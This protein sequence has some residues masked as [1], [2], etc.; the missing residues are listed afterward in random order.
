MRRFFCILLILLL[1]VP[2]LAA[3]MEESADRI[4]EV[5]DGALYGE[6][7]QAVLFVS[8]SGSDETGDGSFEKPFRSLGEAVLHA[9]I[10]SV[11]RMDAGV[12]EIEETVL[13]PA[14]VSVEGA[15]PCGEKAIGGE[16]VL[17]S[18]TLTRE[19]TVLLRLYSE[20]H[21]NY[22][23]TDGNQHISNI[24]FD[25][26]GIAAQAIEV[27]NRNF[28]SVHDC[29]I[30]NFTRIGA[31]FSVDDPMDGGD[32][33]P[34]PSLPPV[35]FAEGCRFFG[36]YM[37]DNS[38]YGPD[39]GGFVWGR[40]AL[41][42]GGL[43]DFRVY[44]NTIIEDCRTAPENERG[45]RIRGVP[46]KFWYFSGW[47]AGCVI[48]DNTIMKLGSTVSSADADG[49]DFA[50]ESACHAG[51]E[52]CHNTF[53]GAIDLNAGMT[54]TFGGET[55]ETATRIHDNRFIP[56]PTPK[57][58]GS[59]FEEWAIVLERITE[60][61]VIERNTVSDC[62]F[63]VYFNVRDSV[64][65]TVIRDN[66]CTDMCPNGGT[67]IR[68]DGMRQTGAQNPM[69]IKNLTIEGN[70]FE[71]R[72]PDR[73]GFGIFLGQQMDAWHGENITIAGN[74]IADPCYGSAVDIGNHGTCEGIE[75][76]VIRD[77]LLYGICTSANLNFEGSG[78][79]IV[80]NNAMLSEEEWRE[81]SA[82]RK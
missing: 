63:F 43:K 13:V 15:L 82:K 35:S 30:V 57:I 39:S 56:D 59:D 51:M 31:G 46:V 47:M 44:E 64:T 70:F 75:N 71:T 7:A 34:I 80:E 20:P 33:E 2:A 28:V 16:T 54:G 62:N 1:A 69:V 58:D 38:F 77:N 52:I 36:N 32:G 5:Y 41:F 9:P 27:R 21:E 18:R 22:G 19:G 29:A 3:G 55:Y 53:T 6:D 79:A 26:M 45:A 4:I 72:N 14:G 60:K 25:G 10:G 24:R 65:D 78:N 48:H 11:I 37:K 67:F 50:I 49:W 74:S 42:C 12:Y 76:L 40:G 8:L 17:T 61:T 68:M 66:L 23:K 81:V 73:A